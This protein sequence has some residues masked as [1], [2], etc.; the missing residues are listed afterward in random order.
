MNNE[1]QNLHPAMATKLSPPA[2][3]GYDLLERPHLLEKLLT[4]QPKRLIL[5]TAAAGYGKSTLMAQG[6][7]VLQQQKQVTAWLTIDEDDNDPVRLFTYLFL[8]LQSDKSA[9][10]QLPEPTRITRNHAAKLTSLMTESG[11]PTILFID[12]FENLINPDSQ[13]LIYWMLDYL[14]PG[15][16]MVIA[17]RTRPAWDLSKLAMQG[18]LLEVHEPDLKL[19]SDE[20]ARLTE[21]HGS[22]R[23]DKQRLDILV[24][25]TEGW[26]AG[27]RLAL[28]CQ[29]NWEKDVD[30]INALS[31]EIEQ[32]ADFLYAQVFRQ[33]E[34]EQQLF[35]L[36]VSIL[37]RMTAGACEALTQE[38]GAQ[39]QL[40]SLCRKGLFIQPI[41]PERKW[42]RMH[43]L[44][45]QFLRNR[46]K[47]QMPNQ[48]GLLHETAARWFA[49]H[50]S[51][52]EAVHYAIAA[53][54]PKLAL[55]ILED[56]SKSLIEKGQ[57][58]T[59]S[60][61]AKHIPDSF[62]DGHYQLSANLCLANLLIHEL[63]SAQRYSSMMEHVSSILEVNKTLAEIPI[64]EPLLMTA[65]DN[66]VRASEMAK[67][68]LSHLQSD[69]SHFER[70]VLSNII[71][72]AELGLGN[73]E[74]SLNHVLQARASHLEANSA[75]GLA[76]ADMITAMRVRSQGKLQRAREISGDVGHGPDYDQAES[77]APNEIAKGVVN[78]FEID[79][80]Y[81]LN[82]LATAEDL[83]K[84]YAPLGRENVA[85]D[86]V[87]LG[88][89]T[90]A[91]IAFAEGNTELAY[92]RL[93]E[94]EI[95]GIRWPLPRLI[96]SM[97]LQRVRFTQLEGKLD[98]A[99][100]YLADIDM[101]PDTGQPPR[102]GYMDPVSE[103][104]ALDLV[105]LRQ[106]LQ[107]GDAATVWQQFPQLIEASGARTG[108][109]IQVLLLKA[110][111][112]SK[113][114]NQDAAQQTLTEAIDL[115]RAC[116][117]IRTF[118]DSGRTIIDL[119]KSLYQEWANKPAP[120]FRER[121]AYCLQLLEA[122]NEAVI[123]GPSDEATLVEPLS[124]RELQML[125]LVGDGL[126][127]EQIA[128]QLFL[129]VNTVKWH[130]RRA[131]E[132][133]D[134]RSRTEALAEA[135]RRGLIQ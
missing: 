51:R 113:M 63:G 83:L 135:R 54:N 57:L 100:D 104:V 59:L 96:Q 42:F 68:N 134:V 50:N 9:S 25:K 97:R 65:E 81:E 110:E 48:Y 23:I 56:V 85:P 77:T 91:R 122:A 123:R 27:V 95:A 33:L 17:S 70:G 111:C 78:G 13:Q 20:A 115:G 26:L 94:G 44:M 84:E 16:R 127:N 108:R 74:T 34:T 38:S 98:L 129:S 35:L 30:W 106:T 107:E 40:Q 89:L 116:G 66:M 80:L 32:I 118:A 31:G 11:A 19:S 7:Q 61:L 88:F 67:Q 128:E 69:Q 103:W 1:Y 18:E 87:I 99:R 82:E 90:S 45:R 37:N 24:D 75:L 64:L 117:F 133:L 55:E 102:V 53:N 47:Q 39:T 14:P 93:D 126:K 114:G 28:L 6:S 62:L 86:I 21:L 120:C 105:P 5:I 52:I 10:L 8:A 73:P 43:G 76:Y 60:D 130:L 112:L 121:R 109:L 92:S 36:K 12:E 132:K 125:T 131:Y 46:L 79:L 124:D 41:D 49:N 2:R 22:R 29:D 72:F 119:L 4:K 15:A 71:A 101:A 58:R 3:W